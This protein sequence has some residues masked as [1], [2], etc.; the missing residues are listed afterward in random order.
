V[1]LNRGAVV[2]ASIGDPSG[3]PRPFLVLRSD[4]FADHSLVTLLAFTSTITD[5]PAHSHSSAAFLRYLRSILLLLRTSTLP[6][7]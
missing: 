5:A 4:R 6:K 3:K 2:T 7:D 1:P